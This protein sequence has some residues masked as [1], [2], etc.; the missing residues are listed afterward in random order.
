MTNRIDF[1]N[2]SI[3]QNDH[4]STPQDCKHEPRH[5]LTHVEPEKQDTHVGNHREDEVGIEQFHLH[6]WQPS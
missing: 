4:Q 3:V 5:G 2:K 1:V 6:C